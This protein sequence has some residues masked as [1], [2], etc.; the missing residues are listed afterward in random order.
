MRCLRPSLE[1][2][3]KEHIVSFFRNTV[4]RLIPPI[5]FKTRLQ[6]ELDADEMLYGSL[7]SV[8]EFA[9][10]ATEFAFDMMSEGDGGMILRGVSSAATRQL[11]MGDSDSASLEVIRLGFRIIA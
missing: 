11:C 10:S 3:G 8:L 1:A 6:V 5:K 4:F 2:S 7:T 9:Y